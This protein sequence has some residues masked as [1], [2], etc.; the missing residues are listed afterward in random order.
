MKIDPIIK[1]A[2]EEIPVPYK[3]VKSK[4]HYFV[5]VEGYPRIIVAGNHHRAKWHEVRGTVGHIQ[6]LIRSISGGCDDVPTK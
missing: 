3:V 2:L 5:Q 6:K 4:D 1:K